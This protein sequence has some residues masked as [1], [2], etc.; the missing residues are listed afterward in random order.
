MN[1]MKRER[2][3]ASQA[4]IGWPD[5]AFETPARARA[6]APLPQGYGNL[7]LERDFVAGALAEDA[8]SEGRQL[9]LGLGLAGGAI[10]LFASGLGIPA[11]AVAF[12]LA[13]LVGI[14]MEIFSKQ[15]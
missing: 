6:S 5:L 9:W 13:P 15:E 14:G 3:D 12:T 7:E 8:R 10:I 2:W 4:G 1:A 11:L